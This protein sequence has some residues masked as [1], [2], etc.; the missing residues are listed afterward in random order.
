[1]T[2]IF[3]LSLLP[4]STFSSG[5]MW[6]S[7]REEERDRWGGGEERTEKKNLQKNRERGGGWGVCCDESQLWSCS[8][9]WPHPAVTTATGPATSQEHHFSNVCLCV[10]CGWHQQQV[11]LYSTDTD[12]TYDCR[13]LQVNQGRKKNKTTGKTNITIKK[14]H[15]C[16][17]KC[18]KIRK[19]NKTQSSL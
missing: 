1:M 18:C 7:H 19:I 11:R 8:G 10:L 16:L 15:L 17:T 9:R 2:E 13:L 3:S 5:Q 6:N 4:R 14:S 12:A